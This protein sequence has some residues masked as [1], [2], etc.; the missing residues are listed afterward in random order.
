M[1]VFIYHA[2]P[3]TLSAAGRSVQIH[4]IYT[5][6][7]RSI[8]KESD[9]NNDEEQALQAQL[10]ASVCVTYTHKNLYTRKQQREK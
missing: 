7:A 6:T 1:T 8:N 2:N 5:H 3:F 10:S 9:L 4:H